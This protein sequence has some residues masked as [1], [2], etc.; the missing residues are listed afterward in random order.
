MRKMRMH[1]PD[2][3]ASR[4]MYRITKRHL[5]ELRRAGGE[6]RNGKPAAGEV[7]AG[8]PQGGADDKGDQ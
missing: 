8:E 5:A 7:R 1:V 2:F 4:G 3:W 6:L